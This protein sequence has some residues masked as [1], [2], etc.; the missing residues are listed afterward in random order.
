[1]LAFAI[2]V[3][4]LGVIF[5]MTKSLKSIA[6][7]LGMR[8]MRQRFQ[9]QGEEAAEAAKA[10]YFLDPEDEDLIEGDCA[11]VALLLYMKEWRELLA[12]AA[13]EDPRLSTL[14]DDVKT[15]SSR[16][17][18]LFDIGTRRMAAKAASVR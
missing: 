16:Q 17:D 1:M 10:G 14:P 8:M 15:P 4:G 18:E 2:P 9:K 5:G 3:I 11:G 13:A 7:S 12:G 6:T